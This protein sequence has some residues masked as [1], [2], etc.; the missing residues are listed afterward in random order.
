MSEVI[1]ST[2]MKT[3]L[4]RDNFKIMGRVGFFD[5]FKEWPSIFM[6]SQNIKD[7][8]KTKKTKRIIVED[9]IQDVKTIQLKH[10]VKM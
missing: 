7:Y 1:C 10:S 9:T 8:I 6:I 4:Y 3:R 2:D 5:R